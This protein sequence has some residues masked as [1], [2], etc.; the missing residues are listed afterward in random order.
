[1]NNKNN[2]M[3]VEEIIKSIKGIIDHNNEAKTPYSI[4]NNKDEDVLELTD[5]VSQ[6]N[7]QYHNNSDHYEEENLIKQETANT[8]S[9]VLKDFAQVAKQANY[10]RNSKQNT[11]EDLVIKMMKPQLKQWLDDN[12]P[13][14]V[15]ELVEKEIRRLIPDDDSK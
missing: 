10:E 14:L 15:K 5:I 8:T 3:S 7:K 9:K 4:S 6:E 1:M 11:V 13:Q 2:E 12:L